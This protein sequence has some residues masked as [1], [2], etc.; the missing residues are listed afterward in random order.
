M[1][2]EEKKKLYKQI[3]EKTKV[4]SHPT[5][6]H[7]TVDSWVNGFP[8]KMYDEWRADC[9]KFYND[10]FWAKIWSDH[11]KA[12]AYDV[13]INSSVQKTE[14]VEEEKENE[15]ISVFG[16]GGMENE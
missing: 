3:D 12:R 10:I 11:Q 9:Y 16:D 5:S 6:V 14:P 15:N 4:I 13:L 1:N 7:E 2:A 8:R